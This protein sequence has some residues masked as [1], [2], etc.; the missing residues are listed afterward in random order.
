VLGVRDEVPVSG[1]RSQRIVQIAGAQRGRVATRQLC[2]AG[3]STS[4]IGRMIASGTLIA[5]HR[6]VYLVGHAAPVRLGDETSALLA[7]GDDAALSGFS[8]AILWG[9]VAPAST[10]GQIHVVVPKQRRVSP[11]GV[12]VHRSRILEPRDVWTRERLPVV[13]PARALLDIAP[14]VSHRQLELAVDRG[15]VDRVLKPAYVADVLRRAGAH[16]GRARLAEVLDRQTGGTTMTRSEAEERVLALIRA[17][18]LSVPVV[19]AKVGGYEVDFF[20]PHERFALEVDGH[21]YHSARSAFERD[22]RKDT[23]LRKLGVTTMRTTWWQV[24]EDSYAL[25]A[26]LAREVQPASP[27]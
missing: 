15:L 3:I 12:A 18:R 16:R 7:V 17:A 23:D 6:G 19:N 8:A 11:A 4:A 5:V 24:T 20:W 27:A 2:A 14:H 26:D 10:D 1:S 25:V 13:S 9:L 22:R 21:R